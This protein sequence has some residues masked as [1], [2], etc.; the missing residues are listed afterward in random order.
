[1]QAGPYAPPPKKSPL[2]WIL[3]GIG[4]LAVI[5]IVLVLVFVVFGSDDA[6]TTSGDNGDVSGP[7]EVVK[8]FFKGMEKQDADMLLSTFEP[9][10][11][12]ELKKALGDNYETFFE[13][14]FFAAYPDSLKVEIRKMETEIDGDTAV[15]TVVDGTMSYTDEYGD[16]VTE[17]ASE[18]EV[19]PTTLVRVDGKWYLSGEAAKEAGFDPEDLKDLDFDNMD[20][21]GSED[22]SKDEGTS[23]DTTTSDDSMVEVVLPIDSKEE[24]FRALLEDP[25]VAQWYAESIYAFY[26]A[27]EQ[28]ARYVLFLFE[29]PYAGEQVPY[30]WFGVDK[31]TGETYEIT[32]E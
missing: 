28:A 5:A 13:D 30:G 9:S 14:Y 3:G 4:L 31:E 6:T 20:E 29:Q 16:K 18:G 8:K 27:E 12:K 24:A 23:S 21:S 10:F 2:P 25:Y 17:E 1:M 32:N 11:R 22:S 26:S 7:E 15:V 19:D